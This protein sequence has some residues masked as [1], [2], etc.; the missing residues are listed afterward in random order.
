MHDTDSI[1]RDHPIADVVVASGLQLRPMGGRLTGVCPFHGDTRPSLVVYPATQS[2][3][4]FGCGA[5]GD[6]IDFVARLNR[7]GFKEAVEMLSG[8]AVQPSNL[9][10]IRCVSE[11][12]AVDP[13]DAARVVEAAAAFYRGALWRTPKALAY[14]RSRGVRE[15][16]IRDHGL[17]FGAPGLSTHLRANGI[18][19]GL[20]ESLGLLKGKKECFAG[21]VITPDTVAG[22]ATWLTGRRLDEREPRYLNLRTEK[23]ILG[24]GRVTGEAVVLV[25]GPFDWLTAVGW[26]FDAAA[27]L[28]TRLSD[29]VLRQLDRFTQ[30]YLAL[31]N[32][33]AGRDAVRELTEVLGPRAIPVHL[34]P[35][36][37]DV[38]ALAKQGGRSAFISCILRA[39]TDAHA[40]Q[41]TCDHAAG[42]AA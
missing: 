2:Y 9:S 27:L 34:P 14:L 22:R 28:G 21:R 42:R 25:E 4:C 32:D 7:L 36:V 11:P 19:A 20:A 13:D 41:S 18:D 33:E 5:G 3:Y 40:R 15:A 26:R 8:T 16:T 23:P 29:R 1:R 17:G 24:L 37:S 6:V 39:A 35:G 30:V 31:D 38:S 10:P 12:P